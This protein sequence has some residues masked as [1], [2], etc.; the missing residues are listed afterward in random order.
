MGGLLI[1]TAVFVPTLLWADLTNAFVW[2]AVLA[3]AAF[4]AIGFFDDYLKVARRSH[5]GLFARYKML[6]QI[7]VGLAVGV[8]LIVLSDLSPAQYHKQLMVP[9]FKQWVPDLG[10]G[11][12]FFAMFVLVSSSNTVNLTTAAVSLIIGIAD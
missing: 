2:I 5:H 9:F 7:V 3:T 1:L 8:A 4:G 12:V 6:A 10:W 11:Y